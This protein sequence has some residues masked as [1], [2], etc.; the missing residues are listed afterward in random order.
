MTPNAFDIGLEVGSCV[1]VRIP[2]GFTYV[3]RLVALYATH[4]ALVE[5]A[6]VADS[7]RFSAF[8]AT[9]RADGME[10]EPYPDDTVV[11]VP[12]QL[13]EIADWGHPPL[14]ERV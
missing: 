4:I 5:A 10:I 11:R 13:A 6:W 12:R 7:G 2:S 1:I 8:L 14:R 9:G 3:G